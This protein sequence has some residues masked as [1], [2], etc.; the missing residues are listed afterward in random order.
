MGIHFHHYA[1]KEH[2]DTVING[3]VETAMAPESGGVCDNGD[4]FSL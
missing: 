2:H 4:G 1:R 3:Y